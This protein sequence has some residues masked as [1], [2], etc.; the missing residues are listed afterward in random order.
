MLVVGV[1]PV[2]AEIPAWLALIAQDL[3]L[4]DGILVLDRHPRVALGCSRPERSRG[5]PVQQLSVAAPGGLDRLALHDVSEPGAPGPG[6][7]RVRVRASSLNYHDYLVVSVDS[8]AA[9]GRIPMADGA[10]VVEA[11]GEGVEEFVEGDAVVS[12]FSRCGRMARPWTGTFK[13]CPETEWMVML[14]K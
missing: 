11:V 5:P 8:R 12:C 6:E 2:E 4:C 7:I 1:F 14:G 3:R 10:G 9:D 13:G